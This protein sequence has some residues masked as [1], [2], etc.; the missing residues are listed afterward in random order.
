MRES[1]DP[2]EAAMDLTYNLQVFT[3]LS[4][5]EQRH[6]RPWSC[7]GWVYFPEILSD[8]KQA[9]VYLSQT[10]L[11]GPDQR[12]K[13]VLPD[14]LKRR[15]VPRKPWFGFQLVIIR[16]SIIWGTLVSLPRPQSPRERIP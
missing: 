15:Q 16:L 9:S 4:D 12:K 13:E 5:S 8:H 2:A 14:V 11:S 10:L 7:I 6:S 1:E 3:S